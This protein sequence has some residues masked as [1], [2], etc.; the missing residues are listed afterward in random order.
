MGDTEEGVQDGRFG[1]VWDNGDT[2]GVTGRAGPGNPQGVSITLWGTHTG[3]N[4]GRTWAQEGGTVGGGTRLCHLPDP[5]GPPWLQVHR[6][7]KGVVRDSDTELGI[8]NAII[9]V[10]GINHDVRTGTGAPG[11]L[12][13]G[14]WGGEGN[15]I[16]MGMKMG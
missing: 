5:L 7:I 1:G 15:G 6:G 8:P 16:G 14:I 2:G 4:P 9:S 12:W 13:D 11:R 10:D 3:D